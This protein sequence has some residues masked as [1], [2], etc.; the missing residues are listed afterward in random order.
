VAH[1]LVQEIDALG[2]RHLAHLVLEREDNPRAA[3]APPAQ[4]MVSTTRVSAFSLLLVRLSA[5]PEPA[6][7]D[8]SLSWQIQLNQV[9]HRN[10][11]FEKALEKTETVSAPEERPDLIL[12]VIMES[13]VPEQHLPVQGPAFDEEPGE[14]KTNGDLFVGLCFPCVHPEPEPGLIKRSF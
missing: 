10:L 8:P 12:R 4:Q 9:F 3:V 11:G 7:A 1:A 14:K 2:R 6:L 13:N 5:C